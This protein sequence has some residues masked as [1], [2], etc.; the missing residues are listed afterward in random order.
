MLEFAPRDNLVAFE[1]FAELTAYEDSRTWICRVCSEAL[2]RL[3]GQRSLPPAL[4]L[5]AAIR[6]YDQLTAMWRTIIASGRQC[7]DGVV[8]IT[9]ADVGP[10]ETK[11]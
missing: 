10:K 11:P 2:A 1:N 7:E 4:V 5:D 9:A 3:A 6:A 8:W